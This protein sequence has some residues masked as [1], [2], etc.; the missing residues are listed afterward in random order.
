MALKDPFTVFHLFYMTLWIPVVI[1][2]RLPGHPLNPEGSHIIL[3]I[4]QI[5]TPAQTPCVFNAF[6]TFSFTS[7]LRAQQM[8]DL[9]LAINY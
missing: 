1:Y 7:L 2:S 9:L 8:K 5:A 4:L 6:G 3:T